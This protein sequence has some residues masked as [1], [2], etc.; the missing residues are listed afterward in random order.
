MVKGVHYYLKA[1]IVACL[2][3]TLVSASIQAA[4]SLAGSLGNGGWDGRG[5]PEP[6]WRASKPMGEGE[7]CAL[8]GSMQAV[9]L[10][11]ACYLGGLTFFF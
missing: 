3:R 2:G 10:L 8:Q 4:S 6:E 9:P 11:L 1:G 5:W 7:P